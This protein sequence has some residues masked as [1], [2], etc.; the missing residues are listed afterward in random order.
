ME[1]IPTVAEVKANLASVDLLIAGLTLHHGY[2]IEDY[3]IGRRDR[4]RCEM[5]YLHN[6]S[7]G[8]RT[9]RRTTDKFGRWCKPKCSIYDRHPIIVVTGPGVKQEAAWLRF[10]CGVYLQSANGGCTTLAKSPH[11]GQPR[12]EPHTYTMV[13]TRMS[14]GTDGISPGERTETQHTIEADPPELCDAW[15]AWNDWFQAKVTEIA[16]QIHA[17]APVFA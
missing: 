3:P 6:P 7:K 9:S 15:D 17:V 5:S 10:G 2:T 11:Y 13:S 16:A 12:R 8:W 14:I 4:G 1:T